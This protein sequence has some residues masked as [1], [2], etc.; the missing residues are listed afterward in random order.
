MLE[1]YRDQE[2][3]PTIPTQPFRIDVPLHTLLKDAD[4]RPASKQL[5][6][7]KQSCE[8]NCFST[9]GANLAYCYSGTRVMK[10]LAKQALHG[11]QGATGSFE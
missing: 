5:N 6:E 3:Y 2:R 11:F 9:L 10:W 8:L 7:M 4:S 1:P